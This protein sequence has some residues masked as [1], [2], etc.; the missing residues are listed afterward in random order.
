MARG[1]IPGKISMERFLELSDRTSV[2]DKVELLYNP[3]KERFKYHDYKVIAV[4]YSS[5]L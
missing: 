3:E 4:H 2:W 5:S 1:G